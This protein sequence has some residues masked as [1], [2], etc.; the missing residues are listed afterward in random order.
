MHWIVKWSSI[1]AKWLRQQLV[2]LSRLKNNKMWQENPQTWIYYRQ[3]KRKHLRHY[4]RTYVN[5]NMVYTYNIVSGTIVVCWLKLSTMYS[6]V[7]L[8]AHCTVHV[9]ARRVWIVEFVIVS[10]IIIMAAVLT[11]QWIKVKVVW[12]TCQKFQN[13]KMLK[14]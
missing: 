3:L 6:D 13:S 12:G 7:M 8:G 14:E 11:Q 4:I 9:R 5:M 2:S 1:H 10:R